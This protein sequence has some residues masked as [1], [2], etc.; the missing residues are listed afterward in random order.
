[1]I[2][3][4]SSLVGTSPRTSVSI[5]SISLLLIDPFPSKSKAWNWNLRA[6]SVVEES[7][8]AFFTTV[9]VCGS[10]R[11]HLFAY[12]LLSSK[13]LLSF[14]TIE[15]PMKGIETHQLSALQ[16]PLP[17]VYGVAIH[18]CLAWLSSLSP[19]PL[20]SLSP[21]LPLSLSPSLPLSLSPSQPSQPLS[22]SP[23]LPLS[24]SPSL[25]LSLSPDAGCLEA[26][27]EPFTMRMLTP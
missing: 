10:L 5:M 2:S 8:T 15:T 19:I 24:L 1:M 21:S 25:P 4:T 27:G 11:C 18:S 12:K 14:R 9:S 13:Y 20:L 6:T 23:S 3:S 22:L 16:Q 7:N 26:G 17:K